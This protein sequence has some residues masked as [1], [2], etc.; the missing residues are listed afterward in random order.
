MENPILIKHNY[1]HA[2][3]RRKSSIHKSKEKLKMKISPVNNFSQ[4]V[5]KEKSREK[6]QKVKSRDK[7]KSN[8]KK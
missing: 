5:F 3:K 2:L 1:F 4:K 7:N 6:H 8:S